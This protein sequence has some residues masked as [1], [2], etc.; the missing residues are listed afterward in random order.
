MEVQKVLLKQKIF[1]HNIFLPFLARR[2]LLFE[3]FGLPLTLM[4]VVCFGLVCTYLFSYGKAIK[5]K[6][7]HTSQ[8][9]YYILEINLI[10]FLEKL[11]KI[12]KSIISFV[13]SPSNSFSDHYGTRRYV[14]K[15]DN[16]YRSHRSAMISHQGKN[17][18][19]CPVYVYSIS[20][21]W[22]GGTSTLA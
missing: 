7:H 6:K 12:C 11:G 10:I 18:S 4:G 14:S 2:V 8:F 15:C 5:T 17:N 3:V 20:I 21:K 13:W 22:A 19:N 16:P 9:F 1:R